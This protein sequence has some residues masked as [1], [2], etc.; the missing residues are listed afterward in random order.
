MRTAL[1][2]VVAIIAIFSCAMVLN[3]CQRQKDRELLENEMKGLAKAYEERIKIEQINFEKAQA[4]MADRF[5]GLAQ[6]DAL[7]N[8]LRMQLSTRTSESS[9][10]PVSTSGSDAACEIYRQRIAAL[11]NALNEA[12]ALIKE[13][14]QCALN[15]NA[16]KQ[17]CG[18]LSNGTTNTATAIQP[19]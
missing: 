8:D 14:D 4:A 12:T 13:R 16:L 3:D 1:L 9:A 15:Y 18:V 17:Q 5:N 11:E 2:Q 19:Q 7:A 6:L 10:V